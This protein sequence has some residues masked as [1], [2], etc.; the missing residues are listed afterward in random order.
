MDF[1]EVVRFHGHVCPGLAMG[2]RAA[3]LAVCELAMQRAGDDELIAIVEN[4][5]CAVDAIQAVAGCTAGKGNLILRDYGKQVYTFIRRG[6]GVALRLAVRWMPAPDGPEAASAWSRFEQGDRSAEVLQ[7]IAERKGQKAKAILEA[8]DS[9]LFFI[10]RPVVPVP[11]PARVHPTVSCSIC[12]ERVMKPRAK[13]GMDG[14]YTCVPCQ[15]QRET[16]G[17]SQLG[18]PQC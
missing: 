1:P 14:A 5:S 13:R 2:F 12:G 18:V 4:A 11:E 8:P 9:E 16:L 3:S 17:H 7:V 15:Q 10:A 6:D